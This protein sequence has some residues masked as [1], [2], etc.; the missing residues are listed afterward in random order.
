MAIDLGDDFQSS[1][2]ATSDANG[3]KLTDTSRLTSLFESGHIFEACAALALLVEAMTHQYLLLKQQ[4][5]EVPIV[6]RR[7]VQIT[8]ERIP[9]FGRTVSL[10]MSS[11]AVEEEDLRLGLARYLEIRNHVTHE[12]LC[13][14]ST[15]DFNEYF[16]LGL[17]ILAKLKPHLALAV[18]ES[19][20][21]VNGSN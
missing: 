17:T 1:F 11:N 5:Y 15:V 21:K 20:R 7:G 18:T 16:S 2:L 14:Y 12:L 8:I 3:K 9:T 19:M 10:L 6:D 4:A 13:G